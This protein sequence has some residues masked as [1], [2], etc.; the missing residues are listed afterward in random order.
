[1][2]TGGMRCGA[3]RPGYR[4]KAEWSKRIDIRRWHSGALLRDGQRFNWT[5][6]CEGEVTGSIGVA[7]T[8]YGVRLEYTVGS[9]RDCRDASQN[10]TITSTECH[11]G[12]TRSWFACP[13][14]HHRA[15]VLFLRSGRFACRKCQRISYQSQSGSALDRV[16]NR[17]YQLEARVEAG[18]PKWQRWTTFNRLL[19]Q[20]EDVSE[21]FNASLAL[22]IRRLGLDSALD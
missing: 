3:G 12:G 16:C 8:G 18:K 15:A 22:A 7:R 6:S 21:Q 9:G 4:F 10:I 13:A 19:N 11:Y 20:Y 1:M 17:F 14:C 5:W 2:G